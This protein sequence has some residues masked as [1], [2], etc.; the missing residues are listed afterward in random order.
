MSAGISPA[1]ILWKMVSGMAWARSARLHCR[2]AASADS[3]RWPHEYLR[4]L[5]AAAKG[6]RQGS[7]VDVLQLSTQ[8]QSVRQPA[9]TYAMLACQL[10]QVVRRRLAFHG[11]IGGDDQ[12]LHLAFG[13][14][15][16]QAI[17]S[18]FARTNAIE[19][20]QA[21]LQHEIQPAVAG[22]LLDR[23]AVGRRLHCAQQV[24]VAAGAGADRALLGFAGIAAAPT[25]ADS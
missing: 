21:A 18:E 9:R 7:A 1:M 10:R 17:E 25:V 11:R 19:R 3:A 2:S 13:Q 16:G 4:H 15:L 22:R 6:V 24:R 12:L 23:H 20:T 14:A 8:R 5:V